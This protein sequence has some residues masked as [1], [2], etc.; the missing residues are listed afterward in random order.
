[1]GAVR[2]HPDARH[3]HDQEAGERARQQQRGGAPDRGQAHPRRERERDQAHD[4][5]GDVALEVVGAVA[6]LGEERRARACAVDHYGAVGEQA[7]RRGAKHRMLEGHA[8]AAPERKL[9]C[10]ARECSW[11]SATSARKCS[12][13]AS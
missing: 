10:F 8:A 2:L 12:P 5:R 9:H 7:K 11:M 1:M 6:A 3:H 4:R 13:R